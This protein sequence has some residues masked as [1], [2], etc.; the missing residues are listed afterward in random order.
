M[1]SKLEGTTGH[2]EVDSDQYNMALLSMIKNIMCGVED[3][4]QKKMAIIMSDKMLHIFWQ[5]PNVA[6][7]NNK[8]QFDTYIMFWGL[9]RA[10]LLHHWI[11]WMLSLESCTHHLATRRMRY[12][13]SV[14]RRRKQQRSKT[15][16]AFY[17]WGET[18]RILGS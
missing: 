12:R 8:S 13:T 6:N 9:V 18:M 17:W 5:K 11:W 15:F 2:K 7:D 3:S 4:L 16:H 1:R 10:G 14:R